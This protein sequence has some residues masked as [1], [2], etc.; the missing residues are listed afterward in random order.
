MKALPYSI[1]KVVQGLSYPRQSEI[2]V[3]NEWDTS[4]WGCTQKI[5]DEISAATDIV[6]VSS[7]DLD[8][9]S[10][11]KKFNQTNFIFHI[12]IFSHTKDGIKE[13]YGVLNP[14]IIKTRESFLGIIINNNGG[15]SFISKKIKQN[16]PID[17]DDPQFFLPDFELNLWTQEKNRVMFSAPEMT[18][19]FVVPDRFS[20]KR[21]S[22]DLLWAIEYV[23]LSPWHKKYN[24]DWVPIRRPGKYPGLSF[25]GGIDST[26]AMCLMPNNTRLFYLERNFESMIKHDNAHRFIDRLKNEGREIISIKSNHE[27]IRTFHDKNPGFSTDYACMAHLILV[28]DFFDLDAAGTGMPLENTYFFHG[29][30]VRDFMES[31]FWKRYAP[32][33]AYLG[34]P[35]YQPVAGCSEIVNNTIVNKN[36]YKGF[37]TSCLRSNVAG[38]TCNTCWKCFRK[39]IFNKLDWNM[40]PEISK[41]LSKRPLKQGIATLY[42]LQMMYNQKQEVPEEANDLIPLMKVDLNFLNHYWSP[43][44]ELLP[45]KYIQSTEKKLNEIVSKMEIDLYSLDKEVIQI[46]RGE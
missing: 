21:T 45:Q 43:S 24:N 28:A 26:A 37:A 18:V 35:I 39:N 15:T 13:K 19:E 11:I 20:L 10:V 32:M 29:S 38:K 31:S 40:S 23:L 42:A 36:G 30:K 4:D 25:S 5:V 12:V 22:L 34:I 44:L 33:F 6:V 46:L 2:R 9:E 3:S 1:F 14:I 27:R 16:E 41:F 17:I 7:N 8:S